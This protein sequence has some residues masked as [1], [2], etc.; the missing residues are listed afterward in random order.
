MKT[1]N[2]GNIRTEKTQYLKWKMYY[3]DLTA[4]W[5]IQKKKANLKANHYKLFK[6]KPRET[7]FF[8]V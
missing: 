2:I 4:N 3:M 8:K 6:L 1:L 7:G 5:T